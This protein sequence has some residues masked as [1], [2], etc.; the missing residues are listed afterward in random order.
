MYIALHRGSKWSYW[1]E[2]WGRNLYVVV[3]TC[4]IPRIIYICNFLF[5]DFR[6]NSF[7]QLCINYANESLQYYFNKHVFSL[8]QQEYVREHIDWTNIPFHDN[9]PT[10]DLI[11]RKP[12]GI[13]H[14]LDDES[15]FPKVMPPLQYSGTSIEK[16]PIPPGKYGLKIIGLWWQVQIYWTFAIKL[17]PFKTVDLS[18]WQWFQD[19][20]PCAWVV[21]L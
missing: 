21:E 7:E 12:H 3:C 11:S 13:I 6:T 5:Q 10:I 9:Q 15:N 2:G 8:E 17:W 4:D 20:F 1:N 19:R 14:L 16:W 18:L